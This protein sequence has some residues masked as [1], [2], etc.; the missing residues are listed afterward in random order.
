[1]PEQRTIAVEEIDPDPEQPR[2]HFDEAGLLALG[3]NMKEIG[4]Q[5]PVIVFAVEVSESERRK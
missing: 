5:A 2:K 1:M 3:Q 4:Q